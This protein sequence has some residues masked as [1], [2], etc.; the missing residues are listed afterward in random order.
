MD[1]LCWS[2]EFGVGLVVGFGF[3]FKFFGFIFGFICDFEFFDFIF[4]FIFVVRFVGF[5]GV[6]IGVVFVLNG[7][8]IFCGLF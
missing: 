2:F 4:V 7:V 5:F 6:L 1:K 3:I 8:I